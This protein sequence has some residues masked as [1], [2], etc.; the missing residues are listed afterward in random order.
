M[1]PTS[2]RILDQFTL[3]TGDQLSTNAVADFADARDL[4]VVVTVHTPATPE[5]DAE[6]PQLFV[7]HAPVND[8]TYY[9]DFPTPVAVDLTVAGTTW[10]H[11]PYFT[12]YVGWAVSGSIGTEPVVSLDVLTKG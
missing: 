8:D 1:Y 2:K 5:E 10:V 9:V 12:R 7:K 6:A 11:V 3:Q 4:E